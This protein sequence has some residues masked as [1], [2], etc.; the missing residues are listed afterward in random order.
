M[1][2]ARHKDEL[3]REDGTLWPGEALAGG[4]NCHVNAAPDPLCGGY[5]VLAW[6]FLIVV[7]TIAII[8]AALYA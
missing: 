4:L 8:V 3:D 6:I 7:S 2:Q 1:L 5:R